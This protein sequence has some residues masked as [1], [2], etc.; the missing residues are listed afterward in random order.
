MNFCHSDLLG[1]RHL[2][3]A[4]ITHLLDQAKPL[5]DV[6]DRKVKQVPTLRGKTVLLLFCEPSTRTRLSFEMA[7]RT[8]GADSLTMDISTSSASKGESLY[9]M[10]KNLEALGVDAI[11]IRH[12]NG[13]APHFVAET[14]KVPVINA[15]DGYNEHPTQGLLDLY[16]MR[17]RCE[18][19]DLSG[20]N[21]LIVGDIRH[22][23]VAK[24]NI[25]GL[26]KLGANVFVSGPPT[27]IPPGIEQMGAYV[28]PNIDKAIPE[29]DFI[30]VLRVQFERQDSIYF[31]SIREY[32][33][34][35]GLTEE[36]MAA[37]KPTV[38][39]LH[40]GP[41][42]RGIEI[43]S[44]VADGPSNVILDQVTNG[45]AVR[46]AVLYALLSGNNGREKT[47]KA[48]DVRP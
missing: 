32:R 24:S 21:V 35:F 29:M 30:N 3:A 40:P 39:V 44:A 17:E 2:S 6:L 43:D 15:G 42:N 46:M 38:T 19:G 26:T 34:Q 48:E 9:D 13:G 31:P 18:D 45:I 28:V 41:M 27:L 14:A 16:T 7:V 36:R 11:V 4:E 1:L 10:V 37:A 20:K 33:Q 5:R 23:R 12:A 8:I 47:D 22:S 25:W